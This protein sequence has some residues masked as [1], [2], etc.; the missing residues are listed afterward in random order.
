M[1]KYNTWVLNI[2]N[3][4]TTTGHAEYVEVLWKNSFIKNDYN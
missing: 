4:E 1:T 3:S 2:Y